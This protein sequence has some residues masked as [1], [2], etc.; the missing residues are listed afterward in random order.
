[1]IK[2]TC[3]RKTRFRTSQKNTFGLYPGPTGAGTCPCATVGEGG[4]SQIK[5]GR[6]LPTCY[7]FNTISA[8]KNVGPALLHNTN[9]IRTATHK[10]R[11]QLLK[12]EFARFQRT[13]LKQAEPKLY[14]RLHWSGDVYDLDYAKALTEAMRAFPDITFWNYTRSLHLAPYLAEEVPHLIQFLSLDRINLEQ[15]LD[16]YYGPTWARADCDN[17]RI[18]YMSPENDFEAKYLA[19]KPDHVFWPDKPPTLVPCPTDEGKL[20]VDGACAKC[21][22]CLNG[23]HIWFKTK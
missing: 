9:L 1:M 17:I 10:E 6:K 3:D 16:I 18:C 22:K 15:G 19:M 8:Y 20:P 4:C 12:D 13:E 14:Y 23:R 7:V 11:V 2:A 21:R 5:P